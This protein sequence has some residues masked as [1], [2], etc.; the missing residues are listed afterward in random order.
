MNL[1]EIKQA[2]IAD[3]ELL[4]EM[5]I[6]EAEHDRYTF[7]SYKEVRS[8]KNAKELDKITFDFL[9]MSGKRWKFENAV[10]EQWSFKYGSFEFSCSILQAIDIKRQ[11]KNIAEC[12]KKASE[13]T[14]RMPNINSNRF[15]AGIAELRRIYQQGNE[16]DE[17]IKQHKK[18]G[19]NDL[20]R[21]CWKYITDPVKTE[22]INLPYS[23][24][25]KAIFTPYREVKNIPEY[26]QT[27]YKIAI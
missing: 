1:N 12:P 3:L 27:Q 13:K 14:G 4:V 11:L 23:E 5:A 17:I 20:I 26:I 7:E 10:D 24:E 8:P 19:K 16:T 6:K 21:L 2:A 18:A 25:P 15:Q 22:G 9:D